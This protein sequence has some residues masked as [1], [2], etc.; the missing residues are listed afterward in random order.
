MKENIDFRPS[1]QS[2][3]ET[4]SA[5]KMVHACY[6]FGSTERAPQLSEG[7]IS[8]LPRASGYDLN[9]ASA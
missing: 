4:A 5:K 2:S 1:P 9:P 8:S 6:L 7:T 3:T